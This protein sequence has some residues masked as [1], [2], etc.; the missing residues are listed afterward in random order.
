MTDLFDSRWKLEELLPGQMD[1]Y[2]PA[3]LV[4]CEKDEIWKRYWDHAPIR[5]PLLLGINNRVALL[6]HRI[7]ATGLTYE[8][9]FTKPEAM[10]KTQLLFAYVARK[11]YHYFCDWPTELPDAWHLDLQFHNVFEAMFFD[12]PVNFYKDQVPDTTPILNDDNKH[13]IF[14]IDINRPLEREP[15]KTICEMTE[16]LV[17][18]VKDKTFLDRPIII[19]PPGYV[20][21]DGPL[22]VAMNVRGPDILFDMVDDQDYANKLFRFI[23]DAALNRRN[24][25]IE[26]YNLP[27]D[28]SWLADDSI[29]LI[30]TDQ[31]REMLLPHHRYWYE[32]TGSQFGKR[33]IHLC[34]DA[35]RHFPILKEEL[36]VTSFD[37][38]FPVDF[39]WLRKTLGPEVEILGGVEI[40]TLTNGTPE[41]VYERSREI[42]TSGIMEGGRF[43]FREG[44]N[45]PPNVPWCNLAAMYKAVQDFGKY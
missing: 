42:L 3:N 24:A 26:R 38:G 7:N 2:K 32:S 11:R 31:Y 34:G 16:F 1:P 27:K 20:G 35:T 17:D 40:G 28:A 19:E 14:D 30:S 22:T 18:Y 8:Q 4:D 21:T 29:A 39:A 41:Q 9:T 10:L 23:F 25:L 5:V 45:L 13:S 12:C 33:S 37:T 43:I 6:D 15:F 36:G 44:N